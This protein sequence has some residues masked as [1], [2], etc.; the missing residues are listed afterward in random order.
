L[1]RADR[2]GGAEVRAFGRTDRGVMLRLD[3]LFAPT[4]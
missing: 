2:E 1:E 4:P 3:E